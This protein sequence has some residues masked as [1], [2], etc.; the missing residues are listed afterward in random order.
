MPVKTAE[1]PVAGLVV[2]PAT[3][4]RK[5]HRRRGWMTP[6]LFLAPALVLLAVMSLYPIGF[7]LT[8]SFV[9]WNGI[10][11]TWDFVGLQNY[12][13]LLGAD[14][15]TSPLVAQALGNTVFMVVFVPTLVIVIGLPLAYVVH[16]SSSSVRGLLRTVF[17]FPY[18]TAGIAVLYA[19]KFLFLPTGGINSTLDQLGLGFLAQPDGWLSQGSTALPSVTTVMIWLLVPFAMLVYLASLQSLDPEVIEA[20]RVDGAGNWSILR[21]MIWPLMRP[22]TVLIAIVC[23]REALQDFQIILLM[24]NGG[25]LNATNTLSFLAYT[26]AFSDNARY[27]YASALGWLLFVAGILL[28]AITYRVMS[29]SGRSRENGSLE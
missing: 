3:R 11:P 26:F 10:R 9:D 5:A 18:V 21:F 27:G 14:R 29:R 16:I 19:W 4:E 25:P 17:F 1:D 23:I 13:G 22:A 7:G 20:A 8:L 6:Y 28:S 15:L 12:I 2:R 24:T